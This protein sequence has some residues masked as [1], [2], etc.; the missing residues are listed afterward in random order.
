LIGSL[1]VD[2][3]RRPKITIAEAAMRGAPPLWFV[4]IPSERDGRQQLSLVA[5]ASNVF[6]TGTIITNATFFSA[7]VKSEAQVGAVRWFADN[8]LVDQLFV[9]DS[10]RNQLVAMSLMFAADGMHHHLGWSGVIHVGG[11][12]TDLG[13]QAAQR[14]LNQQRVAPWTQRSRLQRD[15]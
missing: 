6:P 15:R 13:Q 4:E 10:F 1:D 8:G 3:Q 12:R 5:Y 2:E 14:A 7:P 9:A 11:N